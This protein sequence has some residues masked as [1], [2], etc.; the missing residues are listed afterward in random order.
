LKLNCTHQRLVYADDLK[1]LGENADILEEN[2]EDL[3]VA[4]KQ[5]GLEVNPDKTK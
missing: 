5:I 1:V 2:V 3:L 4:S